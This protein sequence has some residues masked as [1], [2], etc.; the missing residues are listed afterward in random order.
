[1]RTFALRDGDFVIAGSSY[2]MVN[3]I[4]R[5]QQQIGLGLREPFASDRFHTQWGSVLPTWIGTVLD[6][7]LPQQIQAEVTR[8]VRNFIM[9]QNEVLKTRASQG[10]RA[11]VA[12]EEMIVEIV[13][14]IVYTNQDAATV[15][16]VLRTAS[17]QEFTILT[18]PGSTTT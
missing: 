10:L 11:N 18:T 4:A 16:V 7:A 15:K 17:R 9:Q 2:G 14:V 3:G 8:I 12:P 13:N 6:S 1:M 5:A